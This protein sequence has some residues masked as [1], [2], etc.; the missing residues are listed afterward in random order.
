MR[1]CL[2]IDHIEILSDGAHG[3]AKALMKHLDEVG[4]HMA[5]CRLPHDRLRESML[6]EDLGFRFIEMIFQPVLNDPGSPV[7]P[8]STAVGRDACYD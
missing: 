6:L 5:S 8:R 4:V 7:Q 3:D 1:R 2:T